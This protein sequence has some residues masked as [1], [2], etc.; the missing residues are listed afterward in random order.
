MI[1][2]RFGDALELMKQIPDNSI[3]CVV[4]VYKKKEDAEKQGRA[5]KASQNKKEIILYK[6]LDILYNMLYIYKC[7]GG[8]LTMSIV[9]L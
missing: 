5:I 1:D 6:L 3:D 2:L 4:T 7:K 8:E 9:N